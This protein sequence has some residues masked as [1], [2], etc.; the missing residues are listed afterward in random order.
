MEMSAVQIAIAVVGMI[1]EATCVLA[2]I[3]SGNYRRVPFL[4]IFIIYLF[5]T[6]CILQ[7]KGNVDWNWHTYIVTS[8]VGYLF[9]AF[10]CYDIWRNCGVYRKD[11]I[12]QKTVYGV[13]VALCFIITTLCVKSVAVGQRGT[14]ER[15]FLL[16]DQGA[17]IMRA[18]LFIVICISLRLKRRP[19]DGF[20]R[21]LITTFALYA[22][23]SLL[24]H[25][26]AELT[27]VFHLSPE[28]YAVA[29]F[30]SEPV[31]VVLLATLSWRVMNFPMHSELHQDL[32]LPTDMKEAHDDGN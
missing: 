25:I 19:L 22:V 4:T 11:N 24:D 18:L 32:V 14:S 8:Y 17:S 29:G 3:V 2:L 13:T 31:W 6:D 26:V 30:I 15:L 20:V 1:V 12:R 5:V 28:S 9:E 7:V 21:T 16:I 27:S 10:A 23:S